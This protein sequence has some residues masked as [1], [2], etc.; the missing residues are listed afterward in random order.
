MLNCKSHARP[1]NDENIC[2]CF[3]PT[4]PW[5][6]RERGE[7]REWLRSRAPSAEPGA[8]NAGVPEQQCR[9]PITPGRGR[10]T[11]EGVVSLPRRSLS[12]GD[13]SDCALGS[14]QFH[15]V[16]ECS[17]QRPLSL[18]TALGQRRRRGWQQMNSQGGKEGGKGG[19]EELAD[20]LQTVKFCFSVG[21]KSTRTKEPR[22]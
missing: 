19:E 7:G 16:S 17:Q 5:R 14:V 13:C 11:G 8:K 4:R 18:G 1:R 21:L 9:L 12:L 20:G 2:F 22:L 10:S 15:I 3:R 6:S